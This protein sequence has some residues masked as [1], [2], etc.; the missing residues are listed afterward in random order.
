MKTPTVN[1]KSDYIYTNS[2][3][4]PE[5][6]KFSSKIIFQEKFDRAQKS[7]SNTVIPKNILDKI[8]KEFKKKH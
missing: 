4:N 6:D 3:Y 7:L 1:T 5:L 8:N 2:V